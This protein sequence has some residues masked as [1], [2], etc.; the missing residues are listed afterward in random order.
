LTS[1]LIRHLICKISWR[2]GSYTSD[3]LFLPN[4]LS[5]EKIH[6]SVPVSSLSQEADRGMIQTAGYA[7]HVWWN[8]QY[9]LRFNFFGCSFPLLCCNWIT[10]VY[11]EFVTLQLARW[12]VS[13]LQ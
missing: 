11:V 4:W 8:A 2:L 13:L 1:S 6:I 10:H 3:N 5:Y 12:I 9:V 7:E